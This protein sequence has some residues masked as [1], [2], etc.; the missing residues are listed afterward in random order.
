[1]NSSDINECYVSVSKTQED[2]NSHKEYTSLWYEFT[3][4][5]DKTIPY[6]FKSNS[7]VDDF[8]KSVGV[9]KYDARSMRYLLKDLRLPMIQ[10]DETRRII[11]AIMDIDGSFVTK[12]ITFAN[13]SAMLT[14]RIFKDVSS[15]DIPDGFGS[16]IKCMSVYF[17][18]F[19]T[20]DTLESRYPGGGEKLM[21]A[22]TIIV[23]DAPIIALAGYLYKGDY[24]FGNKSLLSKT[25]SA[26]ERYGFNNVNGLLDSYEN[27]APM[28]RCN[29]SIIDVLKEDDPKVIKQ[30]YKMSRSG[31]SVY[32]HVSKENGYKVINWYTFE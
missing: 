21:K 15:D 31:E 8:I 13:N 28:L 29:G 30:I 5:I 11:H 24:E 7:P 3:D 19:I 25:I 16:Y 12:P 26:W 20:I 23:N 1:M 32:E 4:K 2:E 18:S 10:C 6:K 17:R 22:F 9:N 14:F 27:A